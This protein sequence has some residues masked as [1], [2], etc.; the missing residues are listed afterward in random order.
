MSRHF[1]SSLAESKRI[2][3]AR[4]RAA[5]TNA[6]AAARI[7][8]QHGEDQAGGGRRWEKISAFCTVMETVGGFTEPALMPVLLD[9]DA[10]QRN[11]VR[12]D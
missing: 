3:S 8:A 7:E 2:A 1:T 6:Q 10:F 12:L 11:E 4:T 9:L 5:N